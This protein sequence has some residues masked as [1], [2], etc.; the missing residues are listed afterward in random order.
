MIE[1]LWGELLT[2]PVPLQWAGNVC[3]M[4][5]K[6]C[7]SVLG[8]PK[9]RNNPA[10][11]L[12]LLSEMEERDTLVA[13]LLRD[14]M[15]VV[16]SNLVDPFSAS[17]WRQFLPLLETLT[18]LDIPVAFQ[19]RGGRG[20]DEALSIVRP[21]CWYISVNTATDDL[22]AQLEPMA[23]TIQSRFALMERLVSLGH[24]VVLGL[25]P[26]VPEWMPD[27]AVV[28]R[29]AAAAGASGVWMEPLHL[30][31]KQLGA[32]PEADR[33]T[34][35]P[36]VIARARKRTA[37]M[38]ETNLFGRAR[39]VA[40]SLGLAVYTQGQSEPTEF[41]RPYFDTYPRLFPILSTWVNALFAEGKA[42]TERLIG[43]EEF[44]A[45][46]LPS[47]PHGVLPIDSYLGSTAHDLW[48]KRKIAPRMTYAELLEILWCEPSVSRSPARLPVLS[49]ACEPTAVETEVVQLV[50]DAGRPYMMFSPDGFEFAHTVVELAG[51]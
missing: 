20:I 33:D 3:S 7:F 45:A 42:A 11:D 18:A 9:R 43:F 24:R 4:G 41:F 25:N 35:G 44:A 38:E 48:H 47:L 51:V 40:R 14:R 37:T 29:Q 28:L 8:Q 13:R 19:T 21:S 49:Y 27:P 50:D 16:C 15:P 34:L 39:D 2:S 32:M 6:F 31:S 36:K 46:M 26:L 12:S 23:P 30:N 1:P 10:R 5:C 22:R 17:N